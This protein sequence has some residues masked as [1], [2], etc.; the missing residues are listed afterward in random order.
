MEYFILKL[1][2]FWSAISVYFPEIISIFITLKIES[3]FWSTFVAHQVVF[4]NRI[5]TVFGFTLSEARQNFSPYGRPTFFL[6]W[7]LILNEICH[8]KPNPVF[9]ITR[10]I[11][12]EPTPSQ[13]MNLV[14]ER[15]A[16]FYFVL[17]FS[18]AILYSLFIEYFAWQ[19]I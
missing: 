5:L 16:L 7:A 8:Q 14:Q 2:L 10:Q 9:P 11:V 1:D 13:R 15:A 6:K 3:R 17:V 18:L 12:W 19:Q 4:L